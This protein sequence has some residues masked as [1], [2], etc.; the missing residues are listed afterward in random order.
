[1]SRHGAANEDD[2]ALDPFGPPVG[3][4]FAQRGGR[5]RPSP[6][7]PPKSPPPAEAGGGGQ[8]A[9]TATVRVEFPDLQ[10][11]SADWQYLDKNA[12][13]SVLGRFTAALLTAKPADVLGFMSEWAAGREGR[14]GDALKWDP[15]LEAPASSK[16]RASMFGRLDEGLLQ[17]ASRPTLFYTS[18]YTPELS[19]G[20]LQGYLMGLTMPDANSIALSAKAMRS[21]I[22]SMDRFLES[23]VPDTPLDR[24]YAGAVYA[25]TCEL[26]DVEPRWGIGEDGLLDVETSFVLEE[27]YSSPARPI[28][29]AAADL[30]PHREHLRSKDWRAKH[31]TALCQRLPA[32]LQEAGHPELFEDCGWTPEGF[33]EGEPSVFSVMR[34]L[35]RLEAQEPL[36]LS[37]LACLADFSIGDERLL[38]LG[39]PPAD[40][41]WQGQRLWRLLRRTRAAE[42]QLYR[43]MNQ[44]MRDTR[45]V[46]RWKYLIYCLDR[47]LASL[48]CPAAHQVYRGVG[49]HFDVAGDYRE[50]AVV[51]WPAFSSSS[52]SQEVADDF[53]KQNTQTGELRDGTVFIIRPQRCRDVAMWSRFPREKEYL[54]PSNCRFKVMKNL[55][56]ATQKIIDLAS[57]IMELDEV[58]ADQVEAMELQ[59]LVRKS[60]SSIKSAV[61][62][63]AETTEA[64]LVVP[65]TFSGCGAEERAI[66]AHAAAIRLPTW[67]EVDFGQSPFTETEAQ[68]FADAIAHMAAVRW[69]RLRAAEVTAPALALLLDAIGLGHHCETLALTARLTTPC[70]AMLATRLQGT[71]P[72]TGGMAPPLALVHLSLVD[73]KLPSNAVLDLLRSVPHCATL[74][75]LDLS[76]NAAVHA[77]DRGAALEALAGCGRPV[78]VALA[79]PAA[80][81]KLRT[82]GRGK[83]EVVAVALHT[84]TRRVAVAL[85][86]GTNRVHDMGTGAT[87]KEFVR[88]DRSIVSFSLCGGFFVSAAGVM[89]VGVRC[90]GS[91]LEERWSVVYYGTKPRQVA[92]R[93]D[94]PGEFAVAHAGG[95]VLL[96]SATPLPF[97][98]GETNQ[99]GTEDVENSTSVAYSPCAPLLAIAS[100][101][102]KRAFLVPRPPASGKRR[103]LDVSQE[104]MQVDF[105]VDGAWLL[106]GTSMFVLIVDVQTLGRVL[107]FGFGCCGPSVRPMAAFTPDGQ[108]LAVFSPFVPPK[109]L[110]FWHLQQSLRSPLV[111]VQRKGAKVKVHSGV[112]VM[113][114]KV[115]DLVNMALGADM[116]HVCLALP[117]EVALWSVLS[118]RADFFVCCGAVV[119][120][121][122]ACDHFPAPEAS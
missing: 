119:A 81:E 118:R 99:L 19:I 46:D 98:D 103:F 11:H 24:A 114:L 69:L 1:M 107:E 37:G 86:D 92:W 70:V 25:Y 23:N 7:G 122:P 120:G 33:R 88:E 39:P 117:T 13:A 50:T 106:V 31:F 75:S 44:A 82:F 111:E 66:L 56:T 26:Y 112:K 8:P 109:C 27:A 6:D 65:E 71:T 84:A 113:E 32:V 30:H 85:K 49:L 110:T 54:F 3:A 10:Q 17:P 47:A 102:Q 20:A 108:S 2:E 115:P 28:Q 105:S 61:S 116:Q 101:H 63:I 51:C 59:D 40:G 90:F 91:D 60:P 43:Q 95:E 15:S 93:H 83:A 55:G 62:M 80:G 48:P 96:L 42:E 16:V 74:R 41:V 104:P 77:R 64:V 5:K 79:T 21:L 57:Q 97:K 36:S 35:R 76:G 94:Q 38:L 72:P 12:V 34:I 9:V 67:E 87:L 18:S 89:G 52:A 53:I 14:A 68:F 78:R 29:L 73:C 58:A 121:R 45:G 22:K 100:K 4:A